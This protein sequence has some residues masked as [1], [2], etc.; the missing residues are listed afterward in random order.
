MPSAIGS[1]LSFCDIVYEKKIAGGVAGGMITYV[2]FS[3]IFITNFGWLGRVGLDENPNIT[4]SEKVHMRT[5]NC[6]K[7]TYKGF[8][9][10]ARVIRKANSKQRID[11]LKWRRRM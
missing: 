11:F 10:P 9:T 6:T 4:Y 8:F 1:F 5:S 2:E 7:A 3:R